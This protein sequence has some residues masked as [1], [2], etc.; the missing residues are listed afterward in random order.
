MGFSKATPIQQQAIPVILAKHDLIACAQTGTGKTAAYVLPILNNI[1][2]SEKRNL[3]TVIIAPTREL[4]QQID[5]Q[6]EGFSYF[7]GVSSIAIYGGGDGATW[8]QQKRAMEG[9]VDLIIAT[10]GRLIAQIAMGTIKFDHVEHLVLDEAD[11][12]LDMGFYEDILRI[13]KE[14][15]AN[16]QTLLFSA[17]MP[18]KIRALANRIL[19]SP[20]EIN[21]AISKPAEGILQQAYVVH[22]EQKEKL[23]DF[24][25]KEKQFNSVLIFASTKENVKKLDRN[26]QRIGLQAKAIHSDLEQVER[27]TVL[28]EFKNKKLTILIGTDVLS[29]GIDV[30]GIDLVINFDV[31]PDPEDYIHRIGR[32]ARAATTGTAITFINQ[33]D[34]RKFFRIESLIGKEVP[35]M[36]LP[37]E[38]GAGPAYTPEARALNQSQGNSRGNNSG[39]KNKLWRGKRPDRKPKP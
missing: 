25:L 27:E 4:A 35:K 21:I 12:M 15:P 36:P 7:L 17:T 29:R 24:L 3:N 10:P 20:I 31:P 9:G 6:I 19:K 1:V 14:L 8:D 5:Q 39:I 38:L 26:L 2:A 32:T 18:P 11:R 30:E 22:N 13:I 16:R 28:R 37:I 34:Q 33:L 23:I